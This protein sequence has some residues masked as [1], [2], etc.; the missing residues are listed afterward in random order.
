MNDVA[1]PLAAALDTIA[2]ERRDLP[3]GD[4]LD[5]ERRARGHTPRWRSAR[6]V[7]VAAAL[8]VGVGTAVAAG[9]GAFD[10]IAAAN[11]PTT[12]RDELTARQ[13]ALL[14]APHVHGITI[15]SARLTQVRLLQVLP[16]RWKLYAAPAARGGVCAMLVAPR[17][18]AST[19]NCGPPLEPTHPI[20]VAVA[21]L[22][23]LG[24]AGSILFG[25]ARDGVRSITV[26]VD[27][28]RRAVVV[29]RNAYYL[30][31]G[32]SQ[33][34]DIRHVSVTFVDGRRLVLS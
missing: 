24:H 7:L 32:R 8:A 17:R 28:R 34:I 33:H 30:I 12:T 14:Q 10:S 19:T 2:D 20:T 1:D 5:V 16:N 9:T 3:H 26:T 27:G 25:I 4:W 31:S 11:H 6:V 21:S 29:H 23:P 13:R 18:P 22:G 15:V